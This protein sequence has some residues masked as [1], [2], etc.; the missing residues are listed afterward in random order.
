MQEKV[1]VVAGKPM[2]REE[3][4]EI[5]ALKDPE[6]KKDENGNQIETLTPEEIMERFETLLEKNQVSKG[7]SFYLQSKIYFAKE[8]LMQ[9][10]PA[11][12]NMSVWNPE[13]P[14]R[15]AMEQEEEPVSEDK[16][17]AEDAKKEEEEKKK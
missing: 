2:A 6:V 13:G 16:A 14:T 4:L 3:A 11:E 1:G 7:G 10:F 8:H 17:E 12:Y 5:L 9:D 15:K